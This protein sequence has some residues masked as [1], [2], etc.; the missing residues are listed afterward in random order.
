MRFP[1]SLEGLLIR[2]KSFVEPVCSLPCLPSIRASETWN[3][4]ESANGAEDY[5]GANLTD[6]E[7]YSGGVL[8]GAGA[9]AARR[10]ARRRAQYRP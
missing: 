3:G 6:Y 1:A 2:I 5:A 8:V 10:T 4:S 7:Q 9:R